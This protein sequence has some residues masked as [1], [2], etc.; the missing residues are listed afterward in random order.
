MRDEWGR[1]ADM[2]VYE[3]IA[4]NRRRT[5]LPF[6]SYCFGCVCVSRYVS[7]SSQSLLTHMTQ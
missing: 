2:P 7:S 1:E 5:C 6:K 4:C 3:I